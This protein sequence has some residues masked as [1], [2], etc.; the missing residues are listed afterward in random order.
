MS[1]TTKNYANRVLNLQKQRAEDQ[2]CADCRGENPR[3]ASYN[4]GI[5]ICL[6]CSG[7]HRS[8]GAHVSKVKSIDLDNWTK[9]QAKCMKDLG[10]KKANEYWEEKFRDKSTT[11]SQ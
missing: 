6:T 2:V 11:S 5:F 4:L 7:I 3:W 9:E 8:L 10:N 1:S